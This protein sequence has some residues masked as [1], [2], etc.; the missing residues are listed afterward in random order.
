MP[1]E[2][3][4]NRREMGTLGRIQPRQVARVA[5][6]RRAV[7]RIGASVGVRLRDAALD[8]ALLGQAN[9]LNHTGVF[10]LLDGLPPLGS[11][12]EVELVLPSV[13]VPLQARG[14]VVRHGA[15]DGRPGVG[16]RFTWISAELEQFCQALAA[17]QNQP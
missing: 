17:R 7:P 9:N 16:I 10:V 15:V 8:V 1:A 4:L 12:L 6:E 14:V 2:P 5:T 11:A 13:L 3:G